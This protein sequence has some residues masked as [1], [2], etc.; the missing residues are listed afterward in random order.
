MVRVPFVRPR[1]L[2]RA[3]I[4]TRGWKPAGIG[5][6]AAQV[7]E[8]FGP[9]LPF[10]HR[11]P[12]ACQQRAGCSVGNSLV[13]ANASLKSSTPS[14]TR[15]DRRSWPCSGEPHWRSPSPALASAAEHRCQRQGTGRQ[16]RFAKCEEKATHDQEGSCK[17]TWRQRGRAMVKVWIVMTRRADEAHA[18]PR[19]ADA[20][21]DRRNTVARNGPSL[22]G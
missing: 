12:L 3:Q 6:R 21:C 1:K 10:S 20:A 16:S 7:S 19:E 11:H 9:P 22:P 8:P 18:S 4:R 2:I 15:C 13:F 17:A 14:R 5:W